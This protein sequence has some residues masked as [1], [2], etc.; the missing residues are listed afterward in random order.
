MRCPAF[1]LLLILAPACNKT[2]SESSTS[3]ASAPGSARAGQLAKWAGKYQ[4][5]WSS[6]STDPKTPQAFASYALTVSEAA[7]R[8]RVDVDADGT[9]TMTRMVGDGTGSSTSLPITFA[10]C[11][12]DDMFQCS[13][14]KLGDVL[15]TLVRKDGAILLQFGKMGAL[16]GTTKEIRLEPAK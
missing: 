9:Q 5:F 3:A 12:K 2:S 13:S 11:K 7:D 1:V 10:E 4:G 8:Y 16:D 14:Y 15:F 6:G